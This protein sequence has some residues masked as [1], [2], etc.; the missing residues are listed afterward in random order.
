MLHNYLDNKAKFLGIGN[1]SEEGFAAME[2]V[3][4]H[5]WP[6]VVTEVFSLDQVVAACELYLAVTARTGTSSPFFMAPI[7]GIFGDHLRKVARARGLDVPARAMDL[8]GIAL[9]RRCA[10][11]VGQHLDHLRLSSGRRDNAAGLSLVP[12]HLA[13]H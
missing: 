10:A 3:I 1:Y 8:A 6:I 4:E 5:G 2:K 12:N 7:T 9:G 11:L 13:L